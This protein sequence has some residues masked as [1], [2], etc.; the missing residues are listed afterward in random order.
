MQL[1]N[2]VL[3]SARLVRGPAPQRSCVCMPASET[4]FGTPSIFL[5]RIGLHRWAAPDNAAA[6]EYQTQLSGPP[7]AT[8]R[9]CPVPMSVGHDYDYDHLD[10]RVIPSWGYLSDEGVFCCIPLFSRPRANEVA[11]TVSFLT[12]NIPYRQQTT[13]SISTL[14]FNF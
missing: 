5:M 14:F 10:S 13:F 7:N 1:P 3:V 2:S 12:Y 6:L 9:Q 4:R 11:V 8:W